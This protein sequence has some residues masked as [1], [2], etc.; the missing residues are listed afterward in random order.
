MAI[1]GAGANE[2]NIALIKNGPA[3]LILNG[4]NT[5]VG[6]TT[7]TQGLLRLGA[8][9]SISGSAGLNVTAVA[10]TSPPLM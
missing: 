2:N 6:A 9:G 7:V 1:G 3:D 8:T 4:A 5:Y 10:G